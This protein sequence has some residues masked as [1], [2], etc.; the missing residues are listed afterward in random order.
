MRLWSLG[1]QRCVET[2]RIHEEGVWA[3]AVDSCFQ[4]FYSAGRDQKVYVTELNVGE[5][6]LYTARLVCPEEN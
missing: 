1:Q 6:M 2:F 3:L 5:W 4:R